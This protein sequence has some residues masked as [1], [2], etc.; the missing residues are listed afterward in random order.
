AAAPAPWPDGVAVCG[1][2]GGRGGGAAIG[3]VSIVKPKEFGGIT[4]YDLS[5]GD[6]KFWHPNGGVM[7]RP[8]PTGP[9]F[10]GVTPAAQASGGGQAQV[11]N[12]R[13]LVIYGTGRSGGPTS[14]PFY[15]HAL[16]K[17]TG[18]EVAKVQI[19]GKTSAV[20]MTFMHQGKQYIVFATG[21]GTSTAL[22]ALKLP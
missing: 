1:G 12:T 15:L 4:G 11:I 7:C 13:T 6:K 19:P 22:V 2:G 10:D 5:T 21:Q 16:D 3:G 18:R 14:A 17:S 20:P 9:L 8:R